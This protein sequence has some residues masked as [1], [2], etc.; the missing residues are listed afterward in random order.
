MA[1]RSRDP[2]R[3]R[4]RLLEAAARCFAEQGYFGTDSNKIARAAGLAPA[5]FYK[6][7]AD[8]RAVLLAAYEAWVATEWTEVQG[9]LE[10]GR[11]PGVAARLA[12]SVIAHH[13]RWAGLRRS[14]RAAAA[15]DDVVRDFQLEQRRAQ[16]AWLAS[17]P[18]ARP[19]ARRLALL[20]ELERLCDAIA[21]GDVRRL[22]VSFAEMSDEVE[23][24]LGDYLAGL[25]P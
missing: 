5:S 18:G 2:E 3:T 8:K 21:E 25:E 13:R 10:A 1:A 22:G 9:V 24:V 17:L 20:L 15:M 16:L 23:R 14:L 4:R 6:H 19:R 7:F 11:G 12:R